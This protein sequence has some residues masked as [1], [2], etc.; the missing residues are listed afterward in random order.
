MAEQFKHFDAFVF[1]MPIK[2]AED[3]V[4]P[5]DASGGANPDARLQDR[6]S[7]GPTG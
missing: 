1:G 7:H 2:L 6:L 4:S 3:C 5:P